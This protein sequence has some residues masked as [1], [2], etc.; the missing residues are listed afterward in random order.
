MVTKTEF[1]EAMKK[2]VTKTEFTR[3]ID[4]MVTKTEFKCAIDQMVT[5]TEF[6]VAMKKIDGRFQGIDERMQ[7]HDA[8]FTSIDER[9]DRTFRLINARFENIEGVLEDIKTNMYTKQEHARDLVWM[10][11]AM[12]EMDAAREE[13]LL[14]GHQKMRIDDLLFDH[15]KRIRVLEK[16]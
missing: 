9:L 1:R 10:D 8:R 2:M 3:A 14:S 6:T 7:G 11:K 12:A 13:R 16:K 4:Q 5:R 15:E